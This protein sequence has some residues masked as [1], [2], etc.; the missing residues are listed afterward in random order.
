MAVKILVADDHEIVREGIRRLV[1]KSGRP[2]E[3]C[4]EARSGK[5][6]VE[7]IKTLKPDIAILDITMP[8]MS[9]LQAARQVADLNTG[10]RVLVFTMHES[11]LLDAEARESGAQGF[12]LKSQAARDLI[13]AIDSLLSGG[14]FYGAPPSTEKSK[15]E[16][17][18]RNLLLCAGF[19][20]A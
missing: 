13:R 6:A 18:D 20:L 19:A 11:G 9:G 17:K 16:K 4:A 15:D 12:V 1:A 3:I 8:E 5:E 7:M 10:C 2:W 14:T